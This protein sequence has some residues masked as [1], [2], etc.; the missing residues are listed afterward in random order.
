LSSSPQLPLA[1]PEVDLEKIIIK[2]NALRE[3]TS[4]AEPG[5]SND[6]HYSIGTQISSFQP[7][8]ITIVGVSRIVNFGSFPAEFSPPG[9]GLEGETLVTPLSPEITPWFIPNA[10]K[11]FP[12]LGFTTPPPITIATTTERGTLVP[13][14]PPALSPNPLLFPFPLGSSVLASPILTPSPPSYPPP[15]IP[16][17][18]ANPPRNKMDAI[19]AARYAPLVLPHPMNVLLVGDYLKYMP[20]FTGEEDINTEE[21]LFS[22]YNYAC[23]LNIENK[24]VWMRF[25]VQSLDGEVRKWF[26][27]LT[28]RS[29]VRIEALDDVFLRQWGDKKY[30]MH[31]IT[32][33]GYLKREEGEYVSDSN[34][35]APNIM[36][37]EQRDRDINDQKIQTPL[38]NNL[39]TDEERKEEDIDPEIHC[40]GDT[41]PFPHLTQSSYEE[42]LMNG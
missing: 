7:S 22:F 2:G 26:R 9:L 8:V 23:N 19:V 24:D 39:V 6:F 12:T 40:I 34:N 27:G 15:H 14:S 32:E 18:G 36:P 21:N 11:Y 16:M 35:N 1:T 38:Q 4:T 13:S 28:P 29:I 31:Y 30:F 33:F 37:R 25:F 20:K 10:S 42:S 41:S 17:V 3:S 5:I